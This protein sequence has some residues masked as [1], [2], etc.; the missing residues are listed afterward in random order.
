[1]VGCLAGVL[2][3]SLLTYSL[4]TQSINH[5]LT[6]TPTNQTLNDLYTQSLRDLEKL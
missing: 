2:T 1:M 5:S 6:Y 4:T 3:H